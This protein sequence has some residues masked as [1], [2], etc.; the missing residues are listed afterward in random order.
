M[1][2]KRSKSAAV[3]AV[4][5]NPALVEAAEELQAA[6]SAFDDLEHELDKIQEERRK[7]EEARQ[8]AGGRYRTARN[9]LA[10]IFA[11]IGMRVDE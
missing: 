11:P 7:C 4:L 1:K 5:E 3:R 9:A 6:K 10:R 8:R 2:P